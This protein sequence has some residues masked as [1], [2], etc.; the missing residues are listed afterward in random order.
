MISGFGIRF[1]CILLLCFSGCFRKTEQTSLTGFPANVEFFQ[2]GAKIH[3]LDHNRNQL[4]QVSV[5]NAANNQILA[6]L[7]LGGLAN[8]TELVYF[9]WYKDQNYQ[10]RF[11]GLDGEQTW[12]VHTAP[13]LEPRGSI[14]IGVPYPDAN[15]SKSS[16]ILYGSEAHVSVMVKNG[17]EAPINFRIEMTN[18]SNSICFL[19]IISMSGSTYFSFRK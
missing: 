19:S 11:E 13:D 2:R 3:L 9:R 14:R 17:F 12:Q 4:Q 15:P 5:L 6:K 1:L 10:F 8:K 7:D 16:L 18:Y